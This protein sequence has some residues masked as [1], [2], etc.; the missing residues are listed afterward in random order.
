M[1]RTFCQIMQRNSLSSKWV[2]FQVNTL[3]DR[4][5][6]SNKGDEVFTWAPN[7]FRRYQLTYFWVIFLKVLLKKWHNALSEA[8]QGQA[9]QEAGGHSI[10]VWKWHTGWC[11]LS[12]ED[13]L[14][15]SRS[16]CYVLYMLFL[17]YHH[18][19]TVTQQTVSQKYWWIPRQLLLPQKVWEYVIALYE[20]NWRC[21]YFMCYFSLILVVGVHW[22]LGI[23]GG[24]TWNNSAAHSS[25]HY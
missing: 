13:W 22:S 17:S 14:R 18:M 21:F 2:I 19:C 1:C 11:F 9:A 16:C 6:S 24:L 4:D 25:H 5:E 20:P 15:L 8:V 12:T 23:S 3:E 10:T 7:S